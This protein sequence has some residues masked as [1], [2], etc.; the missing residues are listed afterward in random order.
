MDVCIDPVQC[1]LEL[2]LT[3]LPVDDLGVIAEVIASQSFASKFEA[4]STET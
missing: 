4:N 2:L 3:I 1:L